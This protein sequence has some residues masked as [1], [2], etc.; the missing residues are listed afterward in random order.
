[1]AGE[2][3][4]EQQNDLII[5]DD[6]AMLQDEELSTARRG[7]CRARCHPAKDVSRRN[8]LPDKNSRKPSVI[9]MTT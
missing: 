7:G 4:T 5:A 8:W 2:D 9:Q 3:W 6:F 1:M